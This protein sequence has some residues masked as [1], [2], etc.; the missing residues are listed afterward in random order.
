VA[1]TADGVVVGSALVDCYARAVEEGHAPAAARERVVALVAE[2]RK[3][4]DAAVAA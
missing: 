1:G 4:I 3:G 2:I